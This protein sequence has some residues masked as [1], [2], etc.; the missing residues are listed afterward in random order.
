[1]PP[2]S[3]RRRRL[4]EAYYP[5]ARALARRLAG[6]DADPDEVLAAAGHV[7]DAAAEWRGRG[8]FRA[9]LTL[10]VAAALRSSAG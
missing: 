10:H 3:D 7:V 6:P 9:Y 2:L 1:M 8:D 4:A 5:M